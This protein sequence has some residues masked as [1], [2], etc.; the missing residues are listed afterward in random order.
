[1]VGLRGALV[2][3]LLFVIL[4]YTAF[5]QSV[6]NSDGYPMGSAVWMTVEMVGLT[7]RVRLVSVAW[8]CQ[9]LKFRCSHSPREVIVMLLLCSGDIE[10]HVNPGPRYPRYPCT[11]CERAVTARQQGIES[12]LSVKGGRMRGVLVFRT[13]NMSE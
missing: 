4:V 8:R 13:R 7:Q 3:L 11:V 10:V 1:M 9:H 6:H 2:V 5:F 12:V